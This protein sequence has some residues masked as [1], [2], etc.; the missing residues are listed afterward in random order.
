M[1][2]GASLR[3]RWAGDRMSVA[4]R[5][6]AMRARRL[7]RSGP[8]G[9]ICVLKVPLN[10]SN[11][12]I[13][14]L[15]TR[16]ALAASSSTQ[17][18]RCPDPGICVLVEYR[19][20]PALW[21]RCGGLGGVTRG[22][23]CELR[24]C[25]GYL[26]ASPVRTKSQRGFRVHECPYLLQL[27]FQPFG[28]RYQP[29]V[30]GIDSGFPNTT[31]CRLFELTALLEKGSSGTLASKQICETLKQPDIRR[32]A[33]SKGE[34]KGSSQAATELLVISAYILPASHHPNGINRPQPT[35]LPAKA[36]ESP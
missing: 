8:V 13:N 22:G 34:K 23:C 5:S 19:S 18:S 4:S 2:I 3:V 14:C 35:H 16:R 26:F 33:Q 9:V 21:R 29:V 32:D 27:S 10:C 28:R 36:D 12:S 6:M 7:E 1:S 11:T 17:H 24:A 20:S 31:Q 15:T 25:A 30:L